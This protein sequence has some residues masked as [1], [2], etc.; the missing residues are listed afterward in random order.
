MILSQQ[1][2]VH[3]KVLRAEAQWPVKINNHA[4]LSKATENNVRILIDLEFKLYLAKHAQPIL[5]DNSAA[6]KVRKIVRQTGSNFDVLFSFYV[7][8]VF[9]LRS[10]KLVLEFSNN[11]SILSGKT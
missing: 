7:R 10:M 4:L 9:V 8:N 3:D 1:C 6:G 5:L 2:S 11:I